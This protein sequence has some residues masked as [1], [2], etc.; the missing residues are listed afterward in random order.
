[1]LSTVSGLFKL[2][3][4][5]VQMALR[6][7]L[8]NNKG[9]LIGVGW[10]IVQPL[11]QLMAFVLIVSFVF[12][13]RS[14]EAGKT[15]EYVRYVLSGMICWQ[16][17]QRCGEAAP[18]LIRDRI[19]IISQSTYPIETL[20]LSMI[21]SNLIGPIVSVL[22][23]IVLSF[24]DGDVP[25]SILLLPVPLFFLMVFLIGFGWITMV[26]AVLVKDLREVIAL[27]FS[28]LVF[29]SPVLLSPDMVSPLIWDIILV[30][31]L[32]HVV[33]C[34]RD[35]LYGDFHPVSWL[36]FIG[37]SFVTFLIGSAVVTR[38]KLYINEYI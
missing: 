23:F 8:G 25:L 30:N 27:A 24:I 28:L 37:F 36:I 21:I 9:A 38:A 35:V 10:M 11:F 5:A 6:E 15:F 22:V 7:V 19:A 2:R 32:A 3:G 13:A 34:F 1:M 18:S 4:F 17:M 16:L 20:P 12:G 33:F 31:P 26:V 29:V 14:D